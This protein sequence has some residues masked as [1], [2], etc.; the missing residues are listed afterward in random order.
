MT[1]FEQNPG[2]PTQEA[3]DYLSR[4]NDLPVIPSG[5]GLNRSEVANSSN[6]VSQMDLDALLRL[7][8]EIDARLP[9]KSLKELNL[10]EEL[11]VQFLAVKSLQMS[12]IDDSSTPA[13]QKAQVASQVATTLQHLVKMQSEYHTAER[14]KV[15]ENLM[16][17]YMKR[18]PLNVAE[19]FLE[20]YEQLA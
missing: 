10:E 16:V 8:G 7:R 2:T 9:A 11:V 1:N 17:K 20:E 3:V 19:A 12:V 6:D 4:P 14:F 15:I 13:N 18:L 5:N